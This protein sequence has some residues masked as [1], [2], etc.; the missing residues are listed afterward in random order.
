M[1]KIFFGC[2]MLGGHDRVSRNEL[3][4]IPDII[5]GLGHELASRHQTQPG[6]TKEEDKRGKT[7]IHDRDYA[8]EKESDM[9]IFEISN[10]SLGVGGEISDMVHMGKP[11]LCIFKRGLEKTVSNYIQGK[12]GSRFVKTPFEFHAYE[13]LEGLKEKIREF[14][15]AHSKTKIV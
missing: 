9:G 4:R 3:A 1:A 15:V 7:E 2:S 10:P 12:Q 5:E 6:I 14:V 8:W 11:V 13:T